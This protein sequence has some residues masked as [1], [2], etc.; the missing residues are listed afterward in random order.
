M[1]AIT[2]VIGFI[3]IGI[4]LVIGIINGLREHNRKHVM[5]KGGLADGAHRLHDG[6]GQVRLDLVADIRS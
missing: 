6:A 5:E 1:F 2:I 4:G 3:H